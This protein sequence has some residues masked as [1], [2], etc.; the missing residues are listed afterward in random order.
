MAEEQKPSTSK[1]VD[2]LKLGQLGQEVVVPAGTRLV[3]QGE[4]PEFFYVIQSGR[5]KVFR[6]QE[7]MLFHGDLGDRSLSFQLYHSPRAR[8]VLCPTASSQMIMLPNGYLFSN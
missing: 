4:S 3:T 5:V 8:A 7:R 6:E 2:G 1:E